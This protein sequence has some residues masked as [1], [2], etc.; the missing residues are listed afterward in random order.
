MLLLIGEA[1]EKQ[2][3]YVDRNRYEGDKAHDAHPVADAVC[4]SCEVSAPELRY[5]L[6]LD[7]DLEQVGEEGKEGS[8]R[9]GRREERNEAELDDTFVVEED[10]GACSGLHLDLA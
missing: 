7:Q 3:Q 8:E 1:A 6:H 9:E 4:A 5:M 10:E 2:D